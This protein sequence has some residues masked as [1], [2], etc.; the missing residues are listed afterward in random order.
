M[1]PAHNFDNHT[2]NFPLEIPQYSKSVGMLDDQTYVCDRKSMFIGL[3][4]IPS[5]A[6]SPTE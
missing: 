6:D 4:P 3:R 2:T 1:Y 5:N